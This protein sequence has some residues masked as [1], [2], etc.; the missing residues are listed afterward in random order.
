MCSFK[1]PTVNVQ[2]WSISIPLW[3]THSAQGSQLHS[4]AIS[5]LLLFPHPSRTAPHLLYFVSWEGP[6]YFIIALGKPIQYLWWK[7]PPIA[8]PLFHEQ[9]YPAAQL[10]SLA[11]SWTGFSMFFHLIFSVSFQLEAKLSRLNHPPVWHTPAWLNLIDLHSWILQQRSQI[12]DV[13]IENSLLIFPPSTPP[14]QK[15]KPRPKH[16][17]FLMVFSF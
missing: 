17:L 10:Q 14:P 7:E 1:D 4:K 12:W 13:H 15:K 16:V 11:G 9:C 8:E 2:I 3:N 5:T 6:C